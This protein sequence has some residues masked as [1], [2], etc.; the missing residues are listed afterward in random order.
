LQP[1]AST[2]DTSASLPQAAQERQRAEAVLRASE[3]ALRLFI[4]DAPA[5]MALLDRQMRCLAVS[6]RWMLDYPSETFLELSERWKEAYRCALDGAVVQAEEDAFV[7][8]DGSA[9]WVR[10]EVRSWR[11]ADGSVAGVVVFTED[12]SPRKERERD[13]E[14]KVLEKQR[15]C[16]ELHDGV[17]QELTA[18]TLLADDLADALRTDPADAARLAGR[19]AQGLRRCGQELRSVMRGLLPVARD[20]EDNPCQRA[21]PAGE[22][23]S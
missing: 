23:G 9:R 10:W 17:C 16:Q 1:A 15:L 21:K 14:I 18:L 3:E 12:V 20:A 7:R 6:R 11:A 22:P 2:P 13:V 4:E 19:I 5:A 8:A